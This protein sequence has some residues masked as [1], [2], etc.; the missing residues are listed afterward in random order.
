M[1]SPAPWTQRRASFESAA[2]TIDDANGRPIAHA[3]PVSG[4]N[5]QERDGNGRMIEAAPELF[6]EL[7]AISAALEN[8]ETITI[9]SGSV[10]AA[11][12]SA[13]IDKATG[14]KAPRDLSAIRHR[15]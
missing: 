15:I 11:R 7:D 2:S 1:Y 9:E 3:L 10:K 5:I 6:K 12:I 8:G 13:A 14:R 4:G